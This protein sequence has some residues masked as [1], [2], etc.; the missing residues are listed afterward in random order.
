M[1]KVI[2]SQRGSEKMYSILGL[3]TILI[4]GYLIVVF[5]VPFFKNMSLETFT[6]KLVNYD[7]QNERPSPSGAK[8]IYNKT[9][10]YIKR[11]NLPIPETQISVD[12]DAKKYSIKIDY[13]Q[14]V[15]LLVTSF[16]WSFNIHK[17]TMDDY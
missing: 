15:N 3:V 4:V 7:Y 17:M 14:R 13:Y 2:A 8:S 9:L 6:Q 10:N 5:S 1:L 11:K 12:Y 16:D